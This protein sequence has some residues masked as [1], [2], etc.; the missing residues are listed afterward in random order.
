MT[1]ETTEPTPQEQFAALAE[2]FRDGNELTREEV[3]F[4]LG[5]I[6][7]LDVHL[8]VCNQMLS[9]ALGTTKELLN[10]TAAAVLRKCGR[11]DTKIRNKVAAMCGENFE[12]L[13][14]VVQ[15]HGQTIQTQLTNP[16]ED[17]D[18]K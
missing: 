16:Q 17:T 7:G 13:L 18:D 6:G 12:T 14:S 5:L 11:T 10:T 8:R 3:E 4:L 15:L 1:T 2:K 9:A